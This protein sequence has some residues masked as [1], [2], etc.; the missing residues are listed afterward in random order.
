MGYIGG[1]PTED[2]VFTAFYASDAHY[3]DTHWNNE[4]FDELL[5]RGRSELDDAKR[6]V[7]YQEM[8]LLLRDDGGLIVP[9]FTNHIVAT[10][11]KI[12]TGEHISGNW[13]MDNWRAVERWSLV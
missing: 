11:D 9:L 3:N 12:S 10:S 7:I 13:E 4:R 1:R 6:R 2:W 8:Q 5:V